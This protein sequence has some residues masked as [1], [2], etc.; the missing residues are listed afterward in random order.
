VPDNLSFLPLDLEADLA[1]A[2]I[3]D[4]LAALGPAERVVVVAEGVTMYLS[5]GAVSTLFTAIRALIA[6][7]VDVAWTFL[8]ASG[9]FSELA[10]GAKT[11]LRKSGEPVRWALP[12]TDCDGWLSEHAFTLVDLHSSADLA[13]AQHLSPRQI[14]RA[15][16]QPETVCLA[17]SH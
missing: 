16:R 14:A 6:G 15:E 5:A 13:R 10:S 1:L 12:A 4:H 17:R 3:H 11:W 2:G 7:P 9:D 8:D